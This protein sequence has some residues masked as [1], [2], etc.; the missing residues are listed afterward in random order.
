[1]KATVF[2]AGLM[3]SAIARDLVRSSHVEQVVVCDIDGKRLDSLVRAEPSEKLSVKHHDVS[4]HSKTVSLLK[5]FDVGVGA[6]P[7]GLSEHAIGSTLR[8]N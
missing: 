4:H 2:G 1:M 8:W 6:L 3:G 5:H 7:H